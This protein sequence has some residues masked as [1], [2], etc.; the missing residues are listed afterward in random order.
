M[1]KKLRKQK[2]KTRQYDTDEGGDYGDA[3]P[4]HSFMDSDLCFSKY[5]FS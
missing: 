2:M 4:V 1:F 3:V 5:C